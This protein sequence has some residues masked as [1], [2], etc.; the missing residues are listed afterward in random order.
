[1]ASPHTAGL[2]AY[3]LSIYPSEEFDPIYDL[4]ENL[5]SLHSQRILSG[6]SSASH[7]SLYAMA[8]HALP[9]FISSY[10]PTPQF[11]DV[12]LKNA[13]APIPKKLTARQMK[14][15]LV[16][17]ATPSALVGLPNNTINRLIYN[18]ATV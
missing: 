3:L 2:L 1:M 7:S 9:S 4:D 14:K 8:R 11:L 12:V 10:L 13:V 16:E 5:V 15:A 18:N 6:A 17:L